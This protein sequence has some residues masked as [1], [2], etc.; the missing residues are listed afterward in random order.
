[1]NPD[2]HDWHRYEFYMNGHI[3]WKCAKCGIVSYKDKMPKPS[4]KRQYLECREFGK[5]SCGA[6]LAFGLH[7][8]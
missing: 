8:D 3:Q 4:L 5:I 6:Y 1:M 2:D 7:E